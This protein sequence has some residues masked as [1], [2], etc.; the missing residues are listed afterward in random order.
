MINDRPSGFGRLVGLHLGH[1][2]IVALKDILIN[3]VYN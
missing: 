1:W 3:Q 2:A